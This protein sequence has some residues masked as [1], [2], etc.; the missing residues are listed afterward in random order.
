ML[1]PGE[2]GLVDPRVLLDVGAGDEA[3]P[4]PVRTS[5]RAVASAANAATC[6]PSAATSPEERA[7]SLSYRSIRSTRTAS[8][9]R[10]V[11]WACTCR[12]ALTGGT[13]PLQ[14]VPDELLIHPWSRPGHHQRGLT[15]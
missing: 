12:S 11:R 2:L 3:R 8:I 9:S 7:P 1:V 15:F 13:I 10:T 5:T 14:V 4:V 6:L